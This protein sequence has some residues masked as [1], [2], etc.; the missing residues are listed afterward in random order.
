[1]VRLMAELG[2]WSAGSESEPPRWIVAVRDE[3]RQ[4]SGLDFGFRY[5]N[6][7]RE[8]G[9]DSQRRLAIARNPVQRTNFLRVIERCNFGTLSSSRI[10]MDMGDAVCMFV[11]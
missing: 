3:F 4:R 10:P 7:H 8:G 2:R 5:R 11:S 1:M 9:C 6:R